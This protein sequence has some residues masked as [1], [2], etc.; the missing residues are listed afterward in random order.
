[1]GKKKQSLILYVKKWSGDNTVSQRKTS[2]DSG[3][4]PLFFSQSIAWNN[5]SKGSRK[6]NCLLFLSWADQSR[7]LCKIL[8]HRSQSWWEKKK[9]PSWSWPAVSL[10]IFNPSKEECFRGLG[11]FKSNFSS[12]SGRNMCNSIS[13]S[14][15]LPYSLHISLIPFSSGLW[16]VLL[17]SF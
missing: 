16:P 11:F 3:M 12:L 13:W 17:T 10:I 15:L 8:L 2:G 1:M 14:S 7:D 9:L 4:L 6:P 5:L